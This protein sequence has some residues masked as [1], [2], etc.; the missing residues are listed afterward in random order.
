MAGPHLGPGPRSRA[1]QAML[2]ITLSNA[3]QFG[4]FATVGD[5]ANSRDC[6]V[7]SISSSSSSTSSTSSTSSST[8]STSRT[9]SRGA[10]SPASRINSWARAR[11]SIDWRR[12]CERAV[13]QGEESAEPLPNFVSPSLLVVDSLVG[14]KNGI[15]GVV[16][17]RD[18]APGEVLVVSGGICCPLGPGSNKECAA[19]VMS[20]AAAEGGEAS[21]YISWFGAWDQDRAAPDP[22][23]VQRMVDTCAFAT[24]M[25]S[26][27]LPTLRGSVREGGKQGYIGLFG[28]PSLFNHECAPN[29][30]ASFWGKTMI[31][32][33]IASIRAG[34]EVMSSTSLLLL[35]LL[36]LLP[37][38][39]SL[40]LFLSLHL[41]LLILL[42][43][44]TFPLSLSLSL[45]LS[46]FLFLSLSP[47]YSPSL[48]P[49]LSLFL[50][51]I[52]CLFNTLSWPLDH[53][54]LLSFSSQPPL[55][56][57]AALIYD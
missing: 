48:P 7:R 57:Q 56:G 34:E 32:G 38:S 54:H 14:S 45:S 44:L 27:G 6:L 19:K 23:R 21:E 20:E 11:S 46:L 37:L 43:F 15:R 5:V 28:Y 12:A 16:A 9:F 50:M 29:C 42:L 25:N 36:L 49:H 40:S 53:R 24:V 17:T 47:S 41:H 18:I 10:C 31:V 52:T 2:F 33:S 35:L 13:S 3:M 8:G 39:L 26:R 55:P 4:C 51:R 30:W 1:K 22:D